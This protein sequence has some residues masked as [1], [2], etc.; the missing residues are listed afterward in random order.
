MTV[1]QSCKSFTT[2]TFSGMCFMSEM[3][4]TRCIKR[5]ERKLKRKRIKYVQFVLFAKE[6]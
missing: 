5:N 1:L 2:L 6:V 3:Q 4:Q